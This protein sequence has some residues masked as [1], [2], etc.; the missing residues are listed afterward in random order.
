MQF[1]Q[2]VLVNKTKLAGEMRWANLNW[3][4]KCKGA[5]D[6]IYYVWQNPDSGERPGQWCVEGNQAF[7]QD[8]SVFSSRRRSSHF[9]SD[10][11]G[12][13]QRI[14]SLMEKPIQCSII[15]IHT[16]KKLIQ[17]GPHDIA[18]EA[19]LSWNRREVRSQQDYFHAKQKI[20][21]PV[22]SLSLLLGSSHHT[23]YPP[24]YIQYV[25]P[26]CITYLYH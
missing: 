3:P 13:E 2:T 11:T 1:Y 19:Q 25:Y 10:H 15:S 14:I 23:L 17:M 8:L 4:M 5:N 22:T 26:D 6:V 9:V 24:A 7:V 21:L 16:T 12:I 20:I 18:I